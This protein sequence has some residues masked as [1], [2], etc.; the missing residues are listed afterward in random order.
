MK[1]KVVVLTLAFSLVFTISAAAYWTEQLKMKTHALLRYPVEIVLLEENAKTE[2]SPGGM[3]EN[4]A[5]AV[6]QGTEEGMQ[7]TVSGEETVESR[8][9]E[10]Q[11]ASEEVLPERE[12]A[13]AEAERKDGGKAESEKET[14]EKAELRAEDSSQLQDSEGTA[15]E[16]SS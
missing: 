7:G 13:S 6:P 12:K 8:K 16:E 11:K 2:E 14:A 1:R 15:A 5:S 10:E 4:A 9:Q 3:Q